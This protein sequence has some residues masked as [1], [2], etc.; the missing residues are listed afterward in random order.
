MMERV[1]ATSTVPDAFS[2]WLTLPF[3]SQLASVML[4]A[5]IF[6]FTLIALVL[7][8]KAI[9][10]VEVTATSKGVKV[11]FFSKL[12]K[13]KKKK[14]E[15]AKKGASKPSLTTHKFFK[16]LRNA[17][18]EG[19]LQLGN[20]CP[21]LPKEIINLTFLRDCKFKVFQEGMT[22]FVEEVEDLKSDDE[23]EEQVQ[24]IPSVISDLIAKY[25]EMA[26]SIRIELD[27]DRVIYGVPSVYIA[28]FNRWHNDH[29]IMCLKAINS[30][31]G[32][33]LYEDWFA[34]LRACL[35]FLY[36]AFKLTLQDAKKTLND[37]NGDL[38]K[39]IAEI[40][41]YQSSEEK[42]NS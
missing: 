15:T 14:E 21:P 16:L 11:S 7:F 30:V 20:H 41:G 22:K 27:E 9:K 1:V 23:K 10:P 25:T 37:L 32:D 35:D 39:E 17:Q 19:F 31:L 29:I 26:E 36:I 4:I 33:K 3:Q 6:S 38:D 42:V 12:F 40:L 5:G 13:S 8:V 2:V 34:E 24:H 18:T 28:K